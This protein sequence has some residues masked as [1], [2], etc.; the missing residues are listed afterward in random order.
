MRDR[1]SVVLAK[2]VWIRSARRFTVPFGWTAFDQAL[3]AASNL[4][5]TLAVARTGSEGLGR[6]GVAF[7]AY[8]IAMG[9]SRA[10]V[11]EPILAARANESSERSLRA[12]SC[13]LTM[14]V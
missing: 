1:A 9:C 6:F 2:I 3:S 5:I 13:T 14:I 10:L 7:A 8:V 12:A 4:A 11:S